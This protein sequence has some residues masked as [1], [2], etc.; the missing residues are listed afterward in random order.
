MHGADSIQQILVQKI[1]QNIGACARMQGTH[2]L[3]IA[4]VSP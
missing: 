3:N 4:G 1:L 2:R